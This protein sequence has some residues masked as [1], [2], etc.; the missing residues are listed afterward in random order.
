MR[1]VVLSLVLAGALML[2]RGESAAAASGKANCMGGFASDNAGPK[3]GPSM[4]TQARTLNGQIGGE[5]GAERAA[6]YDKD[7][8]GDVVGPAASNNCDGH[9]LPDAPTP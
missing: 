7:S 4:S 8:L 5:V 2:G 9:A 3:F 1:K 6:G